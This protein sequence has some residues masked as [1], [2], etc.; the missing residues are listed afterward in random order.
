MDYPKS[1]PGVGLVAGKFVNEDPVAGRAGSLIPAEWGNATT[2][3]LLA[4][5]AAA[6][7]QPT[8]ADNGQLFKAI[9]RL[10][11]MSVA[12]RPLVYSINQLPN[13]NVGPVVVAECAAVWIWSASGFFTG[14][15]SPLCGR[16]V[17][18]HTAIPLVSEVDAVGGVLSKT[19][20]A[21]L[22]GYA[23]ENNLVVSQATWSAN[24]GAHYFVDV[25]ANTFRVP[26]LR[27][28]FRRFT[29]TDADTAN[30]RALGSLQSS[31]LQAHAHNL[32]YSNTAANW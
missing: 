24:V 5:I 18:G 15:R 7:L 12:S 16:P 10:I 26:D 14:Y 30:A 27:N 20:Y 8:E 11:A 22:W 32:R 2:D 25:D 13:Q 6:G 1:V 4:V 31:Q 29:G 28:M 17:D 9:D 23:R 19:A 21:R 3:E